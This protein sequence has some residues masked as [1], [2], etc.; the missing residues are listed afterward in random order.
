MTT[1]KTYLFY[2]TIGFLAG[3]FLSAFFSSFIFTIPAMDWF[4]EIFAKAIK[5]LTRCSGRGCVAAGFVAVWTL[6][7]IGSLIGLLF[8]RL[9]QK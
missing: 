6:P 9:K 5:L 7:I 8:A 1:K 4:W 2:A 3:T